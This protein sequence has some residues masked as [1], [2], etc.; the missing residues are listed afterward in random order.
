ML[1]LIPVERKKSRSFRD[2]KDDYPIQ[3]EAEPRIS[4]ARRLPPATRVADEYHRPDWNLP[5]V[6]GQ[7]KRGQIV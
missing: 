5:L 7:P 6:T 3:V 2:S 1:N 4:V